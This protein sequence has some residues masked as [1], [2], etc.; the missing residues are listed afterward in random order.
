M[1]TILARFRALFRRRDLEA[2]MVEEMRQHLERRTREK[3]ADG[4]SP[5]EAR[6]AAQHEF[7]GIAQLQEQ[8]RDE[9]LRGL[10][11]LEHFGQD[12]RYAA[13][14][15]RRSPGFTVVIVL[16]LAL[17]IGANTT[18]FSVVHAVLLQPLPF[19]EPDRLVSV[20]ETRPEAGSTGRRVNVPVS[21]ATFLDYRHASR[22]FEQVAAFS[23]NEFALTGRG[24][25]EQVFGAGVT[26]NFFATLG[27]A[28]RIG[29]DFRPEEGR[30]SVEGVVL[31][32]DGFWHR[33][34]GA[35]ESAIGQVITLDGRRMIIIGVMPRSLETTAAGFGRQPVELWVPLVLDESS[36]VRAS[37]AFGVYAR[38][39][40]GATLAAAQVEIDTIMRRLAQEFP[41]TNASRGGL[42]QPLAEQAVGDVSATLWLVFAAVG[43]VQLIACAN[44]ANLL[45]ARA[46]RRSAESALRAALGASRSRLIRQFLT[47][48]LLL[49]VGGCAVGLLAARVGASTFVAALP[50]SLP[51]IE[52]IAID[53][54]VLAFTV[55]VGLLT[56]LIFGL[57][58]AWQ[59]AKADLQTALQTAGRSGQGGAAGNRLRAGLVVGQ[60][61]LSLV[62]LAGAGL[63]VRSFIALRSVDPGFDP[64]H[65]FT[66]R[67]NL[68]GDAYRPSVKRTTF[69]EQ[70]LAQVQSLPGVEATATVFPLPFSAAILNR[71]FTLPG[72]PIDPKNPLAAQFNVVS[73]DYFRALGIRLTQGRAFTERDRE[74]APLVAIVNESFARRI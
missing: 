32:S 4:L 44:I 59:S 21:P 24:E 16:T 13:R 45:L 10:L 42:V 64:R 3:I 56:G 36:T 49:A 30:P 2:E 29:R 41:E 22:A 60:V 68:A 23:G 18:V 73:P 74:G 38:L 6:Y 62:L 67:I 37:P 1:K 40:S 12:L 70:L 19:P 35:D 51:G 48:S 72:Q 31:I 53:G 34:F 50:K 8:C 69:F 20:R 17:G 66:L 27:V 14:S 26:T 71:P 11:W 46:S 52:R 39:K 43:L 15:L 9:R 25:A 58:P 33:R 54:P 5:E 55:G 61:A 63:V 65:V 57:A 28:P 47:E 7:G